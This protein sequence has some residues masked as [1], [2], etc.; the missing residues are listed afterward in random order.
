VS[1]SQVLD[2]RVLGALTVV[3]LLLGGAPIA[4]AQTDDCPTWFPDFRCERQGRYEGF[5]APVT[6]PYLFEDPFITSGVSAWFLQNDFPEKSAFAGGHLSV[7]ALQ[8]RVALTDRLAFIA[9]QDGHPA[10]AT[11]RRMG[12][13]ASSRGTA[14]ASGSPECRSAGALTKE[15]SSRT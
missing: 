10:F 14:M 6:A 9:T 7:F 11:K 5:V 12:P 3:V 13:A 2:R 4:A 15:L 1:V 8:V